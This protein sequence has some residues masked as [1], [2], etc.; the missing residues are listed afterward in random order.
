[1]RSIIILVFAM[2]LCP[3]INAQE[4]EPDIRNVRWGMGKEEVKALED[5]ELMDESVSGE[6]EILW[7]KVSLARLEAHLGY[8]FIDGKLYRVAYVFD[9]EHS[10]DNLYINDFTKI[11]NALYGKYG[12]WVGDGNWVWRNDLYIDDDERMGFAISVGHL[13]R[14]VTWKT[15]RSVITHQIWGD[16][17][18]ISHVLSYESIEYG[19]VAEEEEKKSIQDDI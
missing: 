19:A 8:G 4:P 15:T 3:E 16:N 1:M 17:Y 12:D 18:E 10:N 2:F 5:S 9:E 11:N 14:E 6:K 7:Y 13:V